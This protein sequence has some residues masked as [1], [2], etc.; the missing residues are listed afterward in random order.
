MAPQDL[1][2]VRGELRRLGYLDQGVERFLL[3]DALRPRRSFRSLVVLVLKVA[4]LGG[5]LLALAAAL[6]L[7]LANDLFASRPFDLLPL[8]LHLL[9]PMVLGVGCAFAVLAGLLFVVL[10]VSHT[11]KIELVTYGIAVLAAGAAVLGAWWQARTAVTGGVAL[12]VLMVGVLIVA[13]VLIEVLH[14]ALLAL[15]VRLTDLTPRRRVTRWLVGALAMIL[16]VVLLVLP[17]VLAVQHETA[18]LPGNIPLD[19]SAS[20][21]LIGIDGVLPT[22][23]DYVLASGELPALSSLI[24][25][26]AALRPYQ[27]PAG[28][29]ASLW[30]SVATGLKPTDHGM[31]S[32]DTFRPL[33]VSRPLGRVGWFRPYFGQV[34]RALGLMEYQPV[35]AQERRGW[36]LWELAARGGDPVVSVNW[37]GTYPALPDDVDAPSLVLAH[38]AY[39][40]LDATDGGNIVAPESALEAVRELA[41]QPGEL[42]PG[43]SRLGPSIAETAL[44]PDVFH[45]RLA[46]SQLGVNPRVLA[47]YFPALDIIPDG[48]KLGS[49]AHADLLRWQLGS[50]D[51]LLAEAMN[52]RDAIAVVF[53][54]GRRDATEGRVVL[55]HRAGCDGDDSSIEPRQI[56]SSLA[57]A[58]SLPMSRRWLEPPPG[59]SWPVPS[60]EIDS[61]GDRRV[62]DESESSQEYLESLRSLGYI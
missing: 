14:G 61:F 3:Q 35:L 11:R 40:L 34:E 45:R 24:E 13:Y 46:A 10:Q 16:A 58:L 1:D 51:A 49:P 21:L 44:L 47:V 29:P 52:G 32:I 7:A 37:W 2:H 22:E 25:E 55:W 62:V 59:C 20:V 27:R 43:L 5:A 8:Y 9:P 23:L 26:G 36:F 41:R 30:T 57:R 12:G 17:A 48:E 39:Q 19:T 54:P 33:G 31:V 38:G 50:T 42:S 28:P 6:G 53:D 18:T 60:I 4:L 15:A 56:A